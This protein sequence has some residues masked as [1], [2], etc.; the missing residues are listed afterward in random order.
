MARRADTTCRLVSRFV[1]QYLVAKAVRCYDT[2]SGI[3]SEKSH[4]SAR[5]LAGRAYLGP[6]GGIL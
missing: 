3:P 5:V 1:L 6:S 4:Y 2:T